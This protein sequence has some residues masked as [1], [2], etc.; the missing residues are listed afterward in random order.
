MRSS[1]RYR[2]PLPENFATRSRIYSG[3]QL[4]QGRFAGPVLADDGVDFPSLKTE[5]DSLESVG[6]SKPLVQLFQD[7]LWRSRRR[8]ASFIAVA[9]VLCG[10][11]RHFRLEAQQLLSLGFV[12]I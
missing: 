9:T 1:Q 4:D 12:I 11:H 10:V 5:I 6:R 8:R 3:E 2:L 7:E